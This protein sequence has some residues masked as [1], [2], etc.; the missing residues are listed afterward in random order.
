MDL[1]QILCEGSS[2]IDNSSDDLQFRKALRGTPNDL[3]EAEAPSKIDA[4]VWTPA[5]ATRPKKAISRLK[6]A[7]LHAKSRASVACSHCRG[8]KTKCSGDQPSCK[9]CFALQKHCEY[10]QKKREL[11]QRYSNHLSQGP[12]S[13]FV[14][15]IS[16]QRNPKTIHR[17]TRLPNSLGSPTSESK[18][19]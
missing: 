9:T 17:G 15:R 6:R 10:R 11:F 18:Q 2:A 3:T 16:K 19:K 7:S 14:L 5:Q 1:A 8:A 13:V 4:F 12:N